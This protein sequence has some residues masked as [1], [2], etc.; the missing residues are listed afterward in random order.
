MLEDDTT[1]S[2]GVPCRKEKL[3]EFFFRLFNGEVRKKRIP[4]ESKLAWKSQV[5][6][7]SFCAKKNTCKLAWE[8]H[9]VGQRTKLDRKPK[10]KVMDTR[11]VCQDRRM[12][13]VIPHT[14]QLL[15]E[16]AISLHTA[17]AAI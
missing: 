7:S 4:M 1:G 11:G 12:C 9:R 16:P 17:V 2:M 13:K 10:S 14:S 15:L 5:S 8:M 6:K 3:A